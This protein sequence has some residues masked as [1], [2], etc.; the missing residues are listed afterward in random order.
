MLATMPATT[1]S[2]FMIYSDI[3]AQRPPQF[4]VQ[5]P[6]GGCTGA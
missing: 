5:S 4:D 6:V 1:T 2:F 3:E